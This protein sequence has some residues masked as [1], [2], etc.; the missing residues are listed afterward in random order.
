MKW[1]GCGTSEVCLC[2]GVSCLTFQTDQ[3]TQACYLDKVEASVGAAD[4]Q[5]CDAAASSC[6][7]VASSAKI[8]DHA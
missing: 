5:D 7:S 8:C 1:L 4:D 3:L 2:I 6:L